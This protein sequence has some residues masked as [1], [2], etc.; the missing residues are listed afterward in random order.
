MPELET[1]YDAETNTWN[2]ISREEI[3]VY[4]AHHP[5]EFSITGF[6]ETNEDLDERVSGA[7]VKGNSLD[8][9]LSVDLHRI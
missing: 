5:H 7:N 9:L 8:R 2:W 1:P 4:V 6:D 3:T